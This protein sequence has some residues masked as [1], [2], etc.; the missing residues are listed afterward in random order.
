MTKAMFIGRIMSTLL[1][2]G[3]ELYRRHGS[4]V[5]AAKAELRRIPDFWKDIDDQRAET[6]RQLA[7]LRAQGK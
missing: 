7:E 3:A 2:L 5:A 1:E 6:D 4:N